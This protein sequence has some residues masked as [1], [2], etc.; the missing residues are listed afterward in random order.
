MDNHRCS[1]NNFCNDLD[2]RLQDGT[3]K[4]KGLN[5]I[6]FINTDT[7][8][9]GGRIAVYRRDRSSKSAA[10]RF[11]PFCGFDFTD[12]LKGGKFVGHGQELWDDPNKWE[13]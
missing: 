10:I 13:A 1:E 4:Y 9:S 11:C 6:E 7:F 5:Y 3:G 8:K 12:L 2:S